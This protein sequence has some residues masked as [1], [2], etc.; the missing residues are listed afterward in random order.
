MRTINIGIDEAE[1]QNE[2]GRVSYLRCSVPDGQ[3]PFLSEKSCI[4]FGF[5]PD[6]C[7]YG[8]FDHVGSGVT[9]RAKGYY[10]W[11]S[12]VKKEYDEF[13]SNHPSLGKAKERVAIVGDYVYVPTPHAGENEK[14][15]FLSKSGL[16]SGGVPF[17]KRELFTPEV[18]VEIANFVPRNIFGDRISS[19]QSEEVPKFLYQLKQALP[20]IF[21]AATKLDPSF[22]DRI[23]K[24]DDF[25]EKEISILDMPPGEV[26]IVID[27]GGRGKPRKTARMTWDG[28]RLSGTIAR[29]DAHSLLFLRAEEEP[30]EIS[31]VPRKTVNAAPSREVVERMFEEGKLKA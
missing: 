25:L 15:P 24:L 11:R 4:K 2:R 3:C 19:Y 8:K 23:L 22:E 6:G 30:V 26:D 27:S 9:K 20:E 21:A 17:L 13:Y 10:D 16:L 1:K 7:P 5:I 12:R 31:L 14:V 29:S 28:E 18:A